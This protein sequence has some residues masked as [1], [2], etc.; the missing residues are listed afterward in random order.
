MAWAVL[1]FA[2]ADQ[3]ASNTFIARRPD[4]RDSPDAV[5]QYV[6]THHLAIGVLLITLAIANVLL[7]VFGAYLASLLRASA[8]PSWMPM[9][10]IGLLALGSVPFWFADAGT[11]AIW[12]G[13]ADGARADGYR[14]ISP[15]IDGL[16][17]FGTPLLVLFVAMVAYM[18]GRGRVLPSWVRWFSWAVA[19]IVLVFSALMFA[20]PTIGAYGAVAIISILLWTV[21]VSATATWSAW[22]RTRPARPA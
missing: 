8:R 19:L 17:P 2:G 16:L 13:A 11:A 15:T 1:F 22:V 5:F 21:I 9:A 18:L 6:A 3:V 14:W 20:A 12:F 7:V 4:G 10:A